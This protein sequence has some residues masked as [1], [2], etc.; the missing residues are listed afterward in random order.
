MEPVEYAQHICKQGEWGG[1]PELNILA[2]DVY[3]I[4]VCV[5]EVGQGEVH[6]FGSKEDDKVFLMYDGTHYNAGV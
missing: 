3:K 2:S 6:R 5:I 4:E 1:I